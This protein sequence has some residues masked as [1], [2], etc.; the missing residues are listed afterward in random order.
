MALLT[1]CVRA[2]LRQIG[3]PVL[4]EY[5][6]A[7]YAGALVLLFLVLQYR[8]SAARRLYAEFTPLVGGIS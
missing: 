3:A 2:G 1:L 4:L 7:G 6:Y 5:V 8:T